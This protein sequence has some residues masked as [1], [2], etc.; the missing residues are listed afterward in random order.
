MDHFYHW[1]HKQ[2]QIQARGV[3]EVELYNIFF[4]YLSLTVQIIMKLVL[5]GWAEHAQLIPQTRSAS[6]Q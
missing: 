6:D 2:W 3:Q 5:K 4:E 1:I